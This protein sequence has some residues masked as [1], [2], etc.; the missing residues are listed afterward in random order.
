MS[1]ENLHTCECGCEVDRDNDYWCSHCEECEDCCNCIE[2][3]CGCHID[4]DNNCYNSRCENCGCCT[5]DCCS[6]VSCECDCII[7]PDVQ[8]QCEHCYRC[9]H[10]CDCNSDDRDYLFINHNQTPMNSSTFDYN[11]VTR[12]S[13]T[14]IEISG[15]NYSDLESLRDSLELWDISCEEDGSCDIEFPV[16]PRNGDR[17]VEMYQNFLKTLNRYNVSVN[18]DCGLHCH[19]DT[20]DY[21]Y[22]DLRKL[23]KVF[24]IIENTLYKMLPRSRLDNRYTKHVGSKYRVLAQIAN[25][26]DEFFKLMFD[27]DDF[28]TV[29]RTCRYAKYTYNQRYYGLN[30]TTLAR[31]GTIEFRM[32]SG[33]TNPNKIINWSILLANIVEFCKVNNERYIDALC[34]VY[35]DDPVGLLLNLAPT[36]DV[37]DY[38]I[39]RLEHF[40]RCD[41]GF[42]DTTRHLDTMDLETLAE[43]FLCST[44]TVN[45]V[46][47][48]TIDELVE[49][50]NVD[51]SD[52]VEEEPDVGVWETFEEMC[53]R[54]A[55]V[56]R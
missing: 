23:I 48:D 14:E 44:C 33:T 39:Q 9:S 47:Y 22:S 15:M 51:V 28:E 50:V 21:D 3:N 43:E 7:D 55:D 18:S 46:E 24:E 6:C 4:P 49:S 41:M 54:V 35:K 17:L 52:Y 16:P 38:I 29:G 5:E 32:H 26:M 11:P 37:H 10:C 40:N 30:L 45:G 36:K 1:E 56:G 42:Y 31:Q 53:D 25:N 34:D 19:V 12:Y 20:R 2:C 13:A 27:G 8:L